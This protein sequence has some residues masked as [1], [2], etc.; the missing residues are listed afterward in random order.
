[1]VNGRLMHPRTVPVVAALAAA[2]LMALAATANAA[3]PLPGNLFQATSH[4][5][6]LDSAATAG[7]KHLA[8]QAPAAQ[9]TTTFVAPGLS[10]LGIV[11]QP[12]TDEWATTA[13]WEKDME[14]VDATQAV[15]YFTANAQGVT[16]FQVRLYDVAPDGT[17]HLISQDDKQ[18]VTALDPVPVTF[19]LHAQGTILHKGNVLKLGVFAQTGNAAVVLQYGGSTPSAVKGLVVRWLDSDGDGVADTDEALAGSNPLDPA[20]PP[21]S[22]GLD[23]D[24]DGCADA[25]ERAVGTDLAKVDTDGDGFGDCLETHAGSNPLN[26]ASKPY[27][28]NGNG[29]PDT[30]ETRYFNNTTVNPV[31]VYGDPDH[32]GCN[33][34]CEAA[35]GTDPNN[36]D[37]D[38]DGI[39][40]GD[41]VAAG[42]SPT[43]LTILGTH[44]VPEPVAGAAFFATGSSIALVSFL[45]R[46]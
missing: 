9:A 40:D 6:F 26:A 21:T 22:V 23:S 31:D 14:V 16:V 11:H 34:L 44:A 1:M 35:H 8:D 39:L 4:D 12:S 20:D 29:L 18:F 37:T 32:D 36:P 19:D 41:E 43:S 30:F 33:N 25:F 7:V 46:P 28:R 27:D 24:G 3:T 13:P 5:F 10:V 2:T 17:Q 45:R 42:T 15:L 38:G